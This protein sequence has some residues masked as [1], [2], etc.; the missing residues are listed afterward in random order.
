M[1]ENFIER[2]AKKFAKIVKSGAGKYESLK[3]LQDRLDR[4]LIPYEDENK[5]TF[6]NFYQTELDLLFSKHLSECKKADCPQN[7]T[8]N[9]SKFIVQ[10]LISNL[11]SRATEQLNEKDVLQKEKIQKNI[12][13]V[14]WKDPVWSKVISVAIIFCI[15]TVYSFLNSE[16][17]NTT[18]KFQFHNFWRQRFELWQMVL[19]VIGVVVI[20][21]LI[22]LAFKKSFSSFRYDPETLQ[23]DRNLFNKIRN[24]VLTE[25][26]MLNVKNNT[27]SSCPFKLDKI[28]FIF[29]IN[30]E[31]NKADFEFLNPKIERLKKIVIKEIEKLDALI[32][33]YTFGANGEWISIPSEWE[34]NQPE[35]MRE[36]KE[37]L[38]E[39]EILLSKKYDTFIRFCRHTLKT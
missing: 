23:L 38:L 10:Q 5:I 34:Y 33:T 11:Q 12:I 30:E 20:F 39:Q 6:L 9:N 26:Q 19:G 27:Y 8:S 18:F 13:K 17:Q 32:D 14:F 21:S 1:S 36:A 25:E 4:E 28:G 15:T 16:I 2:E 24:K 35:R 22:K 7:K 37:L 29:L 31:K 3:E